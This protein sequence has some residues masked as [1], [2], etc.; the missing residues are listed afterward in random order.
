VNPTT[1]DNIGDTVYFTKPNGATSSE[2]SV[3]VIV[4]GVLEITRGNNRYIYNSATESNAD[5]NAAPTGTLWNSRFL[6]NNN[7]A[8]FQDN[9]IKNDFQNNK[10]YKDF[11]KNNIENS[12]TDNFIYNTFFENTEIGNYFEENT[13]GIGLTANS[14]DFGKNKIGNSFRKN[15][16]PGNFE[17]NIIGNYFTSN[18]FIDG[19]WG[20]TI[21][22]NFYNNDIEA[23]FDGNDIGHYFEDNMIGQSFQNNK[24]KEGFY[25][26]V[27]AQNFA[28]NTIETG[29]LN[30]NIESDFGFG[31]DEIRGNRIGN[32]FAENH[33][34]EYFYD[35]NI[36]DNFTG[37][38]MSH[39]FQYN[40]VKT[41]VSNTDF[42]TYNGN[43]VSF[44]TN[45]TGE[46]PNE[47]VGTTYS[48]VSGTYS[49]AG[50]T[51][52]IVVDATFDIFV[53]TQ[54]DVIATLVSPGKYYLPYVG[55][56]ASTI[57][58]SGTKIGGLDVTDDVRIQI[59]GVSSPSVYEEYNTEIFT[60]VGG[61]NRLSYYD[62]S[63]I[64]TITDIDK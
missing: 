22:N 11:E 47:V 10:I 3:D 49:Y 21:K 13:I 50:S 4:P 28:H 63:D 53:L 23:F 40:D 16:L 12:F 29:F 61:V 17:S 46:L 18:N 56:T 58:I 42:S 34:G 9:D 24:I 27:I 31:Y 52:S 39:N 35:N 41:R 1:G 33:V 55:F 37:N 48:N 62:S 30:N 57:T 36:S 26:N 8:L 60:K 54:S 7:G 51:S 5:D 2:L 32:N 25:N 44:F 45:F 64:L 6:A 20:N 19:A 15:F 59:D 38:T 43:I 14:S